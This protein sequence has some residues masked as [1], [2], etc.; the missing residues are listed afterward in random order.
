VN[1]KKWRQIR[2]GGNY[3]IK[4]K[5]SVIVLSLILFSS[6]F[7]STGATSRNI[8]FDREIISNF[9]NDS[10]VIENPTVP[11]V[12]QGNDSYCMYASTTMQIKYFGFNITLPEILHDMGNGY[13]H[14]Y[15]RFLPPSRIP[16]GGS[17]VT[18]AN[19]NMELLADGYNLTFND[20]TIYRN[21]S[22]ISLWEEFYTKVKTHINKD[23]PVQ[24]SLDPYRL[25]FWNERFNFSNDT[26][27]GHAVV[28][29]GY[30]DSNNSICYND[31]SAAIYNES[32]NGTYIWEKN[33]VFKKAVESGRLIYRIWT[34]EKLSSFIK[35][36]R[37]ER[38]QKF[39]EYNIKRLNGN[40]EYIY[41]FDIDFSQLP[42]QYRLI[43]YLYYNVLFVSGVN[44]T[45]ALKQGLE[46]GLIHRALTV[47]LYKT[48]EETFGLPLY[49]FFEA[50]FVDVENVSQYLLENKN[51]SPVFAFDGVLLQ[52]E[53]ML[54]RNLT[55]CVKEIGI[56]Y[57][58]NTV[59]KT[60][61]L[62]RDF[63]DEM[64][65]IMDKIIEIQN[66]IIDQDISSK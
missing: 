26:I 66:K 8:Y 32:E 34:F 20:D 53:S 11:Y 31:P 28:I 55:L 48:T 14:L 6:F 22:V 42:L 63:L 17:G 13:L 64:V 38:F 7:Y 30:N 15:S 44:A 27:G 39:H 9:Q 35:P 47:Y 49:L 61:F 4:R 56:I 57:S 58:N 65:D 12:G 51:L 21:N 41:G 52:K 36:T 16:I 23:I 54:W 19:F 1:L 59:I 60:L 37:L 40:L 24:T 43:L 10:H 3:L 2:R 18:T 50:V 62:S 5:L 25:T 45:K 33:E 46:K 29:V